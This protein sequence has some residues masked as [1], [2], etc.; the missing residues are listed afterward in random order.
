MTQKATGTRVEREA[1]LRWVPLAKMRVN[2]LAQRE[3]N[4][5]RVDKLASE[6]DLE[7]LANPTVN[8]RDGLYYVIDGQHRTEALKKWLGD[9][10]WADQ[11]VQCWAYEGLTEEEE[12]EKFLKL[13]DTLTP[14]AFDK[15]R[16]GIKSGRVEEVDIDRIVRSLGL[17]ISREKGDGAIAA[18]GTLRKAYHRQ[19][20][21][22]TLRVIRDAYG[23]AGLE[24]AVIDG[25]SML[26]Q[27]FGREFDEPRLITRLSSA[28]A[29]VNGLLG[30]AETLRRM[31]GNAK[32]QCVAAA[33]VD[34]YNGG[35]GGAKL[36]SW[37]RAD[38]SP[39][40]R[41]VDGAA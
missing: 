23:D 31:T 6:M 38:G 35:R 1:R 26:C 39:P 15:F 18:V 33:A 20:L 14:S 8:L 28:A 27:R 34:I 11:S 5:A 10:C 13:N 4:M 41:A 30:K 19:A 32:G 2:P 16:V 40:L 7:Q 25:I 22:Q 9:D 29:G 36:P 24:A 21:S 37:W 3:L 17:R 12:A